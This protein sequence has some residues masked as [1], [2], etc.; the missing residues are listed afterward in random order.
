MTLDG[1]RP[2]QAR[3]EAIGSTRDL[4]QQMGLRTVRGAKLN[5]RRKTGNTGRTIRLTRV[6]DDSATVTAGGAGVYLER[7]TRPH[8]IRARGKALRWPAH[9]TPTTLG[10]RARTG[11]VRRLGNAAFR[12]AT[13]VRH[14]GTK[15]Q[16]FLIPAAKEAAAEVGI[17]QIVET[18]NQAA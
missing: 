5:V 12:F 17:T 18:W 2:L 8:I 16:P 7:G 14:P 10:G 11:A 4:M 13:F 1:Y 9:G 3:L 15:P 6:T